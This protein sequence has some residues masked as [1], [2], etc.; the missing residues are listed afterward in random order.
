VRVWSLVAGTLE[1]SCPWYDDLGVFGFRNTDSSV[2][3][4]VCNADFLSALEATT[5]TAGMVGVVSLDR[6]ASAPGQPV[7]GGSK[8]QGASQLS[9]VGNSGDL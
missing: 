2:R 5:L 1:P 4:R 3:Q 7:S 6:V 9:M 8:T